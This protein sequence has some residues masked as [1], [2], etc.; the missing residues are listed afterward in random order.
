M[1]RGREYQFM[2][3]ALLLAEKGR[4]WTDPNP[5]V[6]AVVVRAGKIVGEGYH[7]V[8]GGPHAEVEALEQAGSR[9]AGAT[10]YVSLE[11][12]CTYGKT[13]PCTRLIIEKKIRRVV[14]ASP[15][16]NPAHAGRALRELAK[17]GIGVETGLL[18]EE[19][20]RQNEIFRKWIS[21]RRPFVALKM[22]QTLDGKIATEKGRSRW[23]SG[24]LS[25]ALVHRLRSIHQAV[26]VG[27]RTVSHDD[28]RLNVNLEGGRQPVRIVL[29]PRLKIDFKK[30]VLNAPDRQAI[31]VTAE[32]RFRAAYPRYDRKGIGLLGVPS[33]R[34]RLNL[35]RLLER[36]GAM[37]ISSILVEGGGE[38]AAAFLQEKLVDKIY[39]FI[40]P[41]FLGGRRA[42]TSVEGEG[43]QN[44]D[45]A[46]KIRDFSFAKIGEDFLVTGYP[47]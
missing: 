7:R 14:A 41:K 4:G 17:K 12:C 10:L 16:P 19:A 32:E 5:V 47:E 31:V 15:D 30:N 36:V 37:G 43:V 42:V 26:L 13:P 46:V 39:F 24:P 27:T 3:R 18:G 33:K 25:R 23:I 22:A 8:F 35:G 9:A 44:L 38:T 6:G 28:P 2:E 29:D 34:G 40:A 45:E 11:P 21:T 20:L 1:G